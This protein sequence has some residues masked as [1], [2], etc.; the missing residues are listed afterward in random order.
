MRIILAILC[1]WCFSVQADIPIQEWKSAKNIHVIY[2]ADQSTH[3][4]TVNFSF[5]GVGSASDPKGQEG[6]GAL[7]LRLLFERTTTGSDRY[8]LERKLKQLGALNGIHYQITH[9]N[10]HFSV[11]C[12]KEKLKDV[13]KIIK[14]IFIAPSFD[15]KELA[16]MKNFDP[17]DSRLSSSS[18]QVFAQK[19]L[20][21]KIFSPHAYSVPTTGTLD[22]R[23]SITIDDIQQSFKARFSRE[24]LVFSVVGDLSRQQLSD[25]IDSTFGTLPLKTSVVIN[26]EIPFNFDGQITVIPKDTPQSGVVFAQKGLSVNDKDYLAFLIVND[27]LGGKPFTS[28]LWLEA[29]ENKGLVYAIHTDPM[30][31]YFAP[32]WIGAFESD[33][34][35]VNEVIAIIRQEWNNV[36]TNGISE[37][38]FNASKTGLSGGFA[39]NFTTPEGINNMLLHCYLSQIPTEYVNTRNQRLA[40]VSLADVNRVAKTL[41]TPEQLTFVVVGNP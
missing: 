13:F 5:K 37:A 40:S 31:R 15:A 41:L 39:L 3:L 23:Q 8:T 20:L 6:L 38:E 26:P 27:V 21:Q 29:R 30:P 18:E 10:I 36:K 12:P 25:C 32:L 14:T 19:I 9:D 17:A 35:K 1:L 34:T 16:K 7:M 33:N 11:K 24:S 4:V 22:G 2:V 28:R